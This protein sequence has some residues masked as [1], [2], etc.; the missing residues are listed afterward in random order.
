MFP[1]VLIVISLFLFL[2][3]IISGRKNSKITYLPLALKKKIY[4]HSS[5]IYL[6]IFLLFYSCDS[7]PNS[8]NTKTN[9]I[10]TVVKT[11]FATD[12]NVKLVS[13][14]LQLGSDRDSLRYGIC[15]VSIPLSHKV[16]EIESPRWWRFEFSENPEKHVV[17]QD[18]SL[19]SKDIFFGP[20]SKSISPRLFL[21]IHGY[22]VAFDDAAKRTAQIAYDLS[23]DGIPMFYSW[24]SK[25]NTAAYT[26]DSQNIDYSSHNISIFISEI[27]DNFPKHEINLIAHSMGTRGLTEALINVYNK[28]P[29][30]AKRINEVILAAPD[31]DA[32]IF[33]RDIAPKLTK[34]SNSITL[35]ASSNDKALKASKEVNGHPRAGDSGNGLVIFDGIETIDATNLDT[36][37]LGHSYFGNSRPVIA[38]I[39][40]LLDHGVRAGERIG[41]LSAQKG[42]QKY[43]E[44]KK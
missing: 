30:A 17:I 34:N 5:I 21:F 36:G 7:A 32:E 11:L 28:D 27:L 42:G 10:Y 3:I 4:S 35:Y 15:N 43:W 13:G 41:L 29:L 18:K 1:L 44:F 31:I 14:K 40:Q 6:F 38:D 2:D 9:K 16:G 26:H 12:R 25:G 39:D 8:S 33:V 19:T 24:P 23:F 37:F 22:N 20:E